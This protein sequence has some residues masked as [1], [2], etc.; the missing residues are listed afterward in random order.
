MKKIVRGLLM[1]VCVLMM[2]GMFGICAGAATTPGNVK[3]LK[4]S[5]GET[6]V[7]LSWN[8]VSGAKGYLVYR[9]DGTK[10]T[11]VKKTTA[12]KV[13]LTGLVPGRTYQY[14]VKAYKVSKKKVYYSAG[15]TTIKVEPKLLKPAVPKNISVGRSGNNAV[16]I[17]WSKAK[18][19]SGYEVFSYDSKKKTYTKVAT[20]NSK[21]TSWKKSGLA[22]GTTLS[23][24]VRSFRTVKGVTA[25]SGY[26]AVKS[27]TAKA[28]S[29]A[30]KEIHGVQYNA[31][32]K[33]QTT[34]YNYATKKQQV[35]PKGTKVITTIKKNTTGNITAYLRKGTVRGDKIRI[36]RSD[37][38]V[39]G[40]NCDT[41]SDYS[42]AAKEEYI[43]SLRITSSTSKL[44][45]INYYRC[46]LYLFK[47]SA[48]KWKLVSTYGCGLGKFGSA[49]P[50]GK[51]RVKRKFAT[52]GYFTGG[53]ELLFYGDAELGAAIH[54]D[55]GAG[56]NK[57]PRPISHG[58]VR[59]TYSDLNKV[60]NQVGV[61][62]TVYIT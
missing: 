20:V 59:L 17:S 60:Y 1:T 30:A 27:G 57:N 6:T 19:A 44:I 39:T 40:F 9:I 13:K 53:K 33:R 29:S 38:T 54:H 37:L 15:Y 61:G 56:V 55:L 34:V 5:T 50:R 45:W 14:A 47:G 23:L 26:S 18:N 41:K 3:G 46:R 62:T 10:Y 35:L 11:Q 51:F 4:K 48:G 16:A 43:N 28:L 7:T 25:Y 2:S 52:G 8:K 32:T 22:D 31:V 24:A 12:R 36:K 58:C 42:K 21:T 49:T